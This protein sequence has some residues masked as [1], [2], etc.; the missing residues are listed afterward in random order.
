[1]SIELY[2]SIDELIEKEEKAGRNPADYCFDEAWLIWLDEKFGLQYF[3]PKG[4]RSEYI[5]LAEM[6]K[7]P[8]YSASIVADYYV[9]IACASTEIGQ[10]LSKAKAN[11][12]LG[13]KRQ[14]PK[15]YFGY[16]GDFGDV[17]RS[18]YAMRTEGN[19]EAGDCL[20]CEKDSPCDIYSKDMMS[21][22]FYVLKMAIAFVEPAFL[23][24][25]YS[26]IKPNTEFN[27]IGYQFGAEEDCFHKVFF[28]YE[29]ARKA[30]S[31]E[32]GPLFPVLIG[33]QEQ[34]GEFAKR[35][36]Q[37]GNYGCIINKL[38]RDKNLNQRK[39][40]SL[41]RLRCPNG[42]VANDQFA[43]YT[44]WVE[45]H[46][47]AGANLVKRWKRDMVLGDVWNIFLDASKQYQN[48]F[49]LK[50]PV[51]RIAAFTS[52]LE[53]INSAIKKRSEQ[54]VRAIADTSGR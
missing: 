24:K 52:Y 43:L 51:A 50:D 16:A 39:G 15:C 21:N 48:V 53:M 13:R 34:L 25:K 10:R 31:K 29:A 40:N 38:G 45:G 44:E 35:S 36:S 2:S 41:I 32:L 22:F 6:L 54:I 11:S 18:M 33:L 28:V 20:V 3:A 30:R 17:K 49:Y 1:M 46:K 23:G 19:S 26:D 37:I 7:T 27:H 9:R 42:F 12:A 8:E 4:Y 47:L 5:A 14:N